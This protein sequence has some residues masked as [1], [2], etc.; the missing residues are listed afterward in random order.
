MGGW[1][2]R[3]RLGASWFKCFAELEL[4]LTATYIHVYIYIG[5]MQVVEYATHIRDMVNW[6][7]NLANSHNHFCR[8][9]YTLLIH[10][11]VHM[12]LIYLSP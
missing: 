12:F 4:E 9:P 1:V 6:V 5:V 8:I 11:Q 2:E 10:T 3:D 7:T